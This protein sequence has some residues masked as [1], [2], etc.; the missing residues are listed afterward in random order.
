[1]TGQWASQLI[2]IGALLAVGGGNVLLTLKAPRPADAARYNYDRKTP[3]PASLLFLMILGMALLSA[4]IHYVAGVVWPASVWIAVLAYL[5]LWGHDRFYQGVST[6]IVAVTLTLV[7]ADTQGMLAAQAMTIIVCLAVMAKVRTVLVVSAYHGKPRVA[8]ASVPLWLTLSAAGAC[9][10][11]LLF[12]RALDAVGVWM[13][14]KLFD[15]PHSPEPGRGGFVHEFYFAEQHMVLGVFAPLATTLTLGA[16]AFWAAEYGRKVLVVLPAIGWAA[17]LLVALI[18]AW[19]KD[20]DVIAAPYMVVGLGLATVV[21]VWRSRFGPLI[22]D[23]SQDWSQ[24][25][26]RF[27]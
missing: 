9:A 13:R 18:V 25:D 4:T 20:T 16:L 23:W 22:W 7:A 12:P 5:A 17:G 21:A 14:W 27:D 26:H 2:A 10:D 15:N 11:W 19:V 6:L 3:R 8:L 1:M 24:D